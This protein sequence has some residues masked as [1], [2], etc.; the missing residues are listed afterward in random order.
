MKGM[1]WC[2][3]GDVMVLPQQPAYCEF[4]AGGVYWCGMYCVAARLGC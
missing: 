1:D 2:R 4:S 3:Y